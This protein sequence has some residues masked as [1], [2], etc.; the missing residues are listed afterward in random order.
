MNID[1]E[2]IVEANIAELSNRVTFMVVISLMV[3]DFKRQGENFVYRSKNLALGKL[4]SGEE[5]D[6]A[7]QKSTSKF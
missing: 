2:S 6:F 5:K 3:L 1:C 7:L 4:D